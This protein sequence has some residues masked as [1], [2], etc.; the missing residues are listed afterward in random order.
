MRSIPGS[1]LGMYLPVMKPG[2][3]ARE[4]WGAK[5]GEVLGELAWAEPPMGAAVWAP[6]PELRSKPGAPGCA[7]WGVGARETEGSACIVL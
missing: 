2:A 6:V 1:P 4:V 5:T 3:G 7:T